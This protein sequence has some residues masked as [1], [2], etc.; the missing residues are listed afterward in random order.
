MTLCV[1]GVG[2]VPFETRENQLKTNDVRSDDI[3]H[4]VSALS[5]M[6]YYG[7]KLHVDYE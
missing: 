3:T 6:N 7:E 1:Y 5:V 2:N 4:F